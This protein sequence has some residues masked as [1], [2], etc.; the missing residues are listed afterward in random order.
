MAFFPT[1]QHKYIHARCLDIVMDTTRRWTCPLCPLNNTRDELALAQWRQ[2]RAGKFAQMFVTDEPDE[3]PSEELQAKCDRIPIIEAIE[4]NYPAIVIKRS[5]E[6]RKSTDKSQ[7]HIDSVAKWI[8]HAIKTDAETG[9]EKKM[10]LLEK[11]HACNY[12]A[13]DLLIFG[14]TFEMLVADIS[15][16]GLLL[17]RT[18]A[19]TGIIS[20]PP[21]SVDFAKLLL[22]GIDIGLIASAGYTDMDLNH[23]HFTMRGFLAAGGTSAEFKTLRAKIKDTSLC[24]IF[25]FTTFMEECLDSSP[26]CV[27][28]QGLLSE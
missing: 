11:L 24:N 19:T 8:I 10:G 17:D 25:S 14:F 6:K 2:P 4:E 3:E 5:F 26:T 22:A 18:F 16:D 21:L 9:K 23:L 12:K 20:R 7:T 13:R 15:N 27:N 28:Q 1:C